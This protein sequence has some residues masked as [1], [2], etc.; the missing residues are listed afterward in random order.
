MVR[1]AKV[2]AIRLT[3]PT[4]RLNVT[5]N[6]IGR[7]GPFNISALPDTGATVAVIARDIANDNRMDIVAAPGEKL[8]AADNSPLQVTGATTFKIN[9]VP[10]RAIV[11]TSLSDDLLIGWKDLQRLNIIP[12]CFPCLLYTS[13]SPR[14]KRQSRMP[15]SA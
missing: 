4:P 11:T 15:S 1:E 8:Y 12:E 13:P 3:D 10:M 6:P 7:G 5:V 9:D 2:S 14:D